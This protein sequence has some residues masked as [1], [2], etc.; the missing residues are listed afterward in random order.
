MNIS[1]NSIMFVWG[2]LTIL[3]KPQILP[4]RLAKS[5]EVLW[6]LHLARELPRPADRITG[7]GR[8]CDEHRHS[9]ERTR[10][11][12]LSLNSA[13][14]CREYGRGVARGGAALCGAANEGCAAQGRVVV[15]TS[16]DQHR[17]SSRRFVLQPPWQ[18]YLSFLSP[19]SS[20]TSRPKIVF[21]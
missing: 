3:N 14:S 11:L 10:R 4:K 20:Q 15:G 16:I 19:A 17:P 13:G 12:H 1:R 5:S 18:H 2:K 6:E 9:K 21:N 7:E 8:N